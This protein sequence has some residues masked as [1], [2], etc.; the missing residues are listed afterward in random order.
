MGFGSHLS[1][2]CSPQFSGLSF[3]LIYVILYVHFV[4]LP[5]IIEITSS[6]YENP[7]FVCIPDF[8]YVIMNNVTYMCNFVNEI[9]ANK[10]TIQYKWVIDV[11]GLI[12]DILCVGVYR[13]MH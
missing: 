13:A 1:Y 4:N 9:T 3:S 8:C 10:C 5:R 6:Y 12:F 11:F 2:V 7:Y